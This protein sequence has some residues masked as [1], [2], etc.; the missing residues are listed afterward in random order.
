MAIYRRSSRRPLIVIALI[1]AAAGLTVGLVVG[2]A[3]APDLASQMQAVRGDAAPISAAL[4]VV[5]TE[6]PKLLAATAASDP[7]GSEQA[8]ARAKATLAAHADEFRLIDA[9]GTAALQNALDHLSTLIAA[10]AAA[11]DVSAAV[12][13]AEAALTRLAHS[14]RS[15]AAITATRSPCTR[16][17]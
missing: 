7:G 4:E 8:L 16:P 6:Y 14:P 10:R 3:T 2:R 1:A 11:A 13:D 17:A 9:T 12:D 5:R 15:P